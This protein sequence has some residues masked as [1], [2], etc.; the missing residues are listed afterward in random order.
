M[1]N[2]LE[3]RALTKKKEMRLAEDKKDFEEYKDLIVSEEAMKVL[4]KRIV[5]FLK[6]PEN[7]KYN[8]MKNLIRLLEENDYKVHEEDIVVKNS[9]VYVNYSIKCKIVNQQIEIGKLKSR[10]PKEKWEE[11]KLSNEEQHGISINQ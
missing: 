6:K 5:K 4:L 8:K 9:I 11:F 7:S 1:K 2:Y 3:K 10:L